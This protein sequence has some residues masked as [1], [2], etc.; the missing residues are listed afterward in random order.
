MKKLVLSI[1]MIVMV[2]GMASSCTVKPVEEKNEDAIKFKEEYEAL[3]KDSIEMN[4]PSNNKMKYATYEEVIELLESGTGVIYFGFPECPWCRNAV[5]V[6]INSAMDTDLEE[7]LYFNALSIRDK[8]HLDENGNIVVDKEGTAEYYKLL[9][10][11]SAV[12]GPYDGLNDSSIKRLYFPTVVFVKGGK[13][14]LAHEGT[15]ESQTDPTKSLSK[16][17][18]DELY[19]IYTNAIQKVLGILCDKD[20]AC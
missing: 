7:V 8:K 14:I 2:I 6:L 10:K 20:S 4:V 9:E 19:Q 13:I 12:L 18:K 17:Q 16:K 5:P 11:L 15:L 3:N 1:V